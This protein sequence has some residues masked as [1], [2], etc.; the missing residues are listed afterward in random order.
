MLFRSVL[1]QR[2]KDKKREAAKQERF[3]QEQ[4]DRAE[5]FNNLE[6]FVGLTKEDFR[7]LR[8]RP[9]YE[10]PCNSDDGDYWRNEMKLVQVEIYN[11]MKRNPV[12]PQQPLNMDYLGRKAY[13]ADAMWVAKKLGLEKLMTTQQNY[14]VPMVQKFFATVVFDTDDE[15][16]M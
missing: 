6:T 8:K 1:R 10:L 3:V 9:L 4:N 16:T 12:C 15:R 11:K 14:D 13:F 7:E 2:E 5:M